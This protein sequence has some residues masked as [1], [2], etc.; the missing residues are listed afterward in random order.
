[1][2]HRQTKFKTLADRLGERQEDPV[3]DLLY[4]KYFSNHFSPA[5]NL[6]VPIMKLIITSKDLGQS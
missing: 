3:K 2:G 6:L 1:M 4:L 5:V